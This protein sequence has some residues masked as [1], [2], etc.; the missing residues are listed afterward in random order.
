MTPDSLY[1][2]WGDQNHNRLMTGLV[3]AIFDATGVER[4]L[5]V[6]VPDGKEWLFGL[7]LACFQD[8]AAQHV[9]VTK[10]RESDDDPTRRITVHVPKAG[11][12]YDMFSGRY[13]GK[14]GFRIPLALNEPKGEWMLK[15]TDVAT[16]SSAEAGF[17]VR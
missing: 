16:Q 8:G 6:D 15:L 10:R 17:T 9:G 4:V 12:I 11:H 5:R 14:A 7:D 13:V 2:Y 3:E 1:G